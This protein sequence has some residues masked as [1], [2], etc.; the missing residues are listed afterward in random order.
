MT[1]TKPF[2][3]ILC[4]PPS[5]RYPILFSP[6]LLFCVSPQPKLEGDHRHARKIG[7]L[8]KNK[9]EKKKLGTHAFWQL[10]RGGAGEA[11]EEK[12][13]SNGGLVSF[14]ACSNHRTCAGKCS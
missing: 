2:Y 5:F 12:R 3:P 6:A 7:P 14:F 10:G 13:R 4:F 9:N 11:E 8:P 1:L